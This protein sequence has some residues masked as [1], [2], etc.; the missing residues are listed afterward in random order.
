MALDMPDRPNTNIVL[1]ILAAGLLIT[2]AVIYSTG[3]IK[4][5]NEDQGLMEMK[6]G[7][8]SELF[9]PGSATFRN[10]HESTIG[11]CGEVNAKNRLGGYVGYKEFH[12]ARDSQTSAWIVAYD[13]KLV[14]VFCK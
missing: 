12:A 11:Y 10:V 14:R 9:D 7:V 3:A 8:A 1:A 5:S 4:R 13:P 2:G 6:N